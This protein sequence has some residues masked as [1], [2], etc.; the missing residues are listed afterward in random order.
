MDLFQKMEN[1]L[2]LLP[3]DREDLEVLIFTY[4]IKSMVT[5]DLQSIL[6]RKSIL[7]SMKTGHSLSIREKHFSSA[8]R[9][10]KILEDMI[11]SGQICSQ[12]AYGANLK[13]WDIR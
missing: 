11:F 9:D 12:M 5:G 8:P 3:T 10:M 4:P 7:S 2:F 6:D 13:I 1:S